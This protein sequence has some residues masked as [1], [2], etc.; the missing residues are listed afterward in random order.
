MVLDRRASDRSALDS[1]NGN[2]GVTGVGGNAGDRVSNLD[3]MRK[4]KK[5]RD[6]ILINAEGFRFSFL[7]RKRNKR[8]QSKIWTFKIAQAII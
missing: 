5:E 8:K 6:G 3:H 4:K 7:Y 1:G 2:S